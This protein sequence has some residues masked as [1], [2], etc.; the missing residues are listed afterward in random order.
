MSS[1]TWA[2][3]F[4]GPKGPMPA[5]RQLGEL[6]H[7]A[8]TATVEPTAPDGRVFRFRITT[9]SVDRDNDTISPSGW[10]LSNY[11]RNPVVLLGHRYGD[12]PVGV[13]RSIQ[14]DAT[15]LTA[16]IEV[17]PSDAHPMG[18]HVVANI[19]RGGLRAT[20]VGFRPLEYTINEDR[21]GY[22]FT[23]QELLEI[24]LV[25]VPA[26]Q[27]ALLAA[28][29]GG[30]GLMV[31]LLTDLLAEVKALKSPAPAA[32]VIEERP[33]NAAP[34]ESVGGLTHPDGA[35]ELPVAQADGDPVQPADP[36]AAPPAAPAAVAQADGDAG[37]APAAEPEDKGLVFE[38]ADE[39]PVLLE[40]MEPDAEKSADLIDVDPAELAALV[41]AAVDSAFASRWTALTG[42]LD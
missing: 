31:R 4:V 39:D 17:F 34:G 20:S 10:D 3:S 33:D 32:E 26:N 23:K 21:R 25:S 40:L 18:D 35:V 14:A 28:S 2:A 29:A 16:E 27:D 36:A 5:P 19:R 24:S 12:L 9:G 1:A 15:G 11:I 38:F 13:C 41:G 6:I 22:D 37:T 42:R 30:D 8:L 7:K